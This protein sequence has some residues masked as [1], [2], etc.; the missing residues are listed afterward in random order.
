MKRAAKRKLKR[1]CVVCGKTIYTTVFR[2]GH[3]SRGHY[4]GTLRVPID[5]TGEYKKTGSMQFGKKK[6]GV[7]KWTGKEKELEYWECNACFEEASHDCWLEEKIEKLVGERCK[8][9][10]AGCVVCQARSLYDEIRKDS[11]AN[12][13]VNR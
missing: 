2:G 11:K 9:F 6:F 10:E 4:F 12:A 3:Y 8:E 7:V 13:N 5:G 1:K